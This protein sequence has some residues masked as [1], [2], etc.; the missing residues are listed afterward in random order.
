MNQG[1][2]DGGNLPNPLGLKTDYLW[3]TLLTPA[4]L[5]NI[6]EN[7][8]QIVEELNPKTGRKK[9]RTLSRATTSLICWC[10][11]CSP[12]WP[13]TERANAI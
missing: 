12:T 9:R 4:S 2:N 6:I 7:Y 5:T 1:W 10:G 11:S 8:A 13:N 3:K